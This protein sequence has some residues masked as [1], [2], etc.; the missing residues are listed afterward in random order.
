ME[1]V[2]DA[3][4]LIVEDEPTAA[5]FLQDLLTAEGYTVRAIGT[6]EDALAALETCRPDL[7]L[8]DLLLPGIDGVEVARRLAERGGQNHVPIILMTALT[9]LTFDTDR[10]REQTGIRRFVLKPCRPKTL[11][12]TIEETLRS[13]RR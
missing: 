4:V 10:L 9:N 2:P 5:T 11:L 6:G 7:I 12:E 3:K 1:T 8:L 13:S